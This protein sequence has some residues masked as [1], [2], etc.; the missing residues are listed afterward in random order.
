VVHWYF[1]TKDD[2]FVAALEALQTEDP[3]EADKRSSRSKPGRE[4]KDLEALLTR[5]VWRRLD[6]F[7]LLATLHERSHVSSVVA[8][9]HERA[10][11]RYAEHLGRALERF[12]MP[13]AERKLAVDAFINAV[14]GLVMHRASKP[15]AS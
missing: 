9:F 12:S 8:A 10:H 11:R 15:E 7:G 1:A 2:L 13:A 3:S 6:R 4:E 5:F 14:E